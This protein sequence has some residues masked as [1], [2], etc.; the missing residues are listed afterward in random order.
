MVQARS[1]SSVERL[2]SQMARSLVEQVLAMVRK[3]KKDDPI[4]YDTIEAL[5]FDEMYCLA[6]RML[7]TRKEFHGL[8]KPVDIVFSYHYTDEANMASVRENGLMNHKERTAN[9]VK[10]AKNNGHSWGTGI[11]STPDPCATSNYGDV[12]LLVACLLGAKAGRD[13][14][15]I[16]K[17]DSLTRKSHGNI[18]IVIVSSAKQ[19][20][21]ILQFQAKQTAGALESEG[22]VVL[23]RYHAK[24]QQILG[25]MFVRGPEYLVT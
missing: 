16:G 22:N 20:F 18:E 19:C 12:G 25:D 21:P 9:D 24:L 13:D 15:N 6:L 8:G 17:A 5:P 1:A 2:P 23:A 3:M 14:R 4:S 11:Y 7:T 10:S